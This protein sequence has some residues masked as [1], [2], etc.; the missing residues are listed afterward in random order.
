MNI[1]LEEGSDFWS[2]DI[3]EGETTSAIKYLYEPFAGRLSE[4]EQQLQNVLQSL[5]I[6]EATKEELDI[7]GERYGIKRKQP[8]RASGKVTMSRNSDS[9]KDYLIQQ[10]T[11]VQ[12]N[13]V[14]PL[15]FQTT[16]SKK[17][18]AGT[19][20]VT[21]S[22]EAIE[23]G[24]DYNVVSGNIT[25][26]PVKPNGIKSVTNKAPI[27]GGKDE[28]T[29][30]SYR[31]RILTTLR[32]AESASGWNIYKELT[33]MD[34]INNVLFVDKKSATPTPNLSDGDFEITI[35][36]KPGYE[37]KIAQLIFENS[38]MGSN[39]VG[40]F[41]GQ[42]QIGT[43]T[44]PNGQQ[45]EIEYSKPT[46]KEIHIDVKIET[47]E[48]I[49]NKRVIS[50]I[51]DYIGGLKTDDS[52]VSGK[53]QMGR[54]VVYGNVDFHIRKLDEVVDIVELT[55]GTGSNPTQTSSINISKSEVAT[56]KASDI[57]VITT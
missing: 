12:T 16:E 37:N 11:I 4:L 55:I 38:P 52:E 32:N 34:F 56:I 45:F 27:T 26:L 33:S 48:P 23:N 17:L 43:A 29:D 14:D 5:Q 22:I 7:L 53:L 25:E 36:S 21:V 30:T 46:R 54:D 47:S 2:D 13:S 51:V 6:T 20:E 8:E 15:R 35:D 57:N 42:K 28:E 49:P 39:P 50:N 10:G 31:Q 40:G 9:P 44:L 24:T 19:K 41:R 3:A 1:M 18:Q